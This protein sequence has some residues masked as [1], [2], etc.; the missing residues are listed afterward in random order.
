M[1]KHL[2]GAAI[3]LTFGVVSWLLSLAAHAHPDL[4]ERWY[5]RGVYQGVRWFVDHSVARFPVAGF[6]WFWLAVLVYWVAQVWH[7]PV[8]P[9]FFQK[10]GFWLLKIG[11]F[12]GFLVGAFFWLWGFNYARTPLTAQLDLHP[13]PLDSAALWQELL[14]ETHAIDSLRRHLVG[15]DTLAL[16]GQAHWPQ[17]AEDSVRAAVTAWLREQGFPTT[18]CVRGR[19]I[20]PPGLLYKFGSAGLYWPFVGEGNVEAGQH[21]LR[22]LPC[23]AHE[24]AHG[25]GFGD[26]GVCNFIA[27]VACTQQPNAYLAYAAHLDHWKTLLNEGRTN[28]PSRYR[29]FFADTVQVQLRGVLADVAA[30][31][32]ERA[33]YSELAPKIRYEVYDA[34][35]NTQ[36]VTA[37][38]ES[39]DEVLMLVRAWRTSATR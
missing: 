30:I 3:G 16:E 26:E 2:R 37:G 36:G 17:P 9:S 4:T 39:Y 27:Y 6:H 38:M 33:R 21:P 1:K 11:G 5:S 15:T 23:M 34:Y 19:L 20:G 29:S 13:I 22:Q 31:R 25:Y 8:L 10:M 18:G 12:A 14:L 28:T 24:M 35:L 32:R 7:R